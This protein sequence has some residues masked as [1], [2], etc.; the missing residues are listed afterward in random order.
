MPPVPPIPPPP[1]PPWPPVPPPP[2]PPPPI[3]PVPPVPPAPPCAT[4][5]VVSGVGSPQPAT[6]LSKASVIVGKERE[7]SRDRRSM[8]EASGVDRGE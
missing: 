3:P 6:A 4:P 5:P 7:R 8:S 2:I 1:W